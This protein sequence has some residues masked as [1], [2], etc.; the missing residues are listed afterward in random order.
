M[1]DPTTTT[2]V[3]PSPWPEGY[4][5]LW[6]N[7]VLRYDS[8]A[9]MAAAIEGQSSG[10]SV[11]ELFD[12]AHDWDLNYEAEDDPESHGVFV[13]ELEAWERLAVEALDKPVG[14]FLEW[15][16]W[17]TVVRFDVGDRP[18][19]LAFPRD[20]ILFD[21]VGGCLAMGHPARAGVGGAEQTYALTAAGVT[22][23]QGEIAQRDSRTFDV[24][25]AVCSDPDYLA[26]AD[27]M[28][29]S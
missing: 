8:A 18:F 7:A 4:A 15:A 21:V 23:L 14:G 3:A 29:G 11:G 10:E 28:A 6:V 27:P 26:E 5:Y 24:L 17:A 2:E 20:G 19:A 1:T 9:E 13:P 16:P 25:D 22:K 12:R